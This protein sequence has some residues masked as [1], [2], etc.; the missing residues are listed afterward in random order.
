MTTSSYVPGRRSKPTQAEHVHFL[1][2]SDKTSALQ[3]IRLRDA[4]VEDLSL[5][6]TLPGYPNIELC[7]H[8]SDTT[9]TIDNVDEYIH[10]VL[11]YTLQTGVQR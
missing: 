4:A 7:P 6:F 9:V 8:G 1:A 10:A 11:K 2:Q 3:N 5:D